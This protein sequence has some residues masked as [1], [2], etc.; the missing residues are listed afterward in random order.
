[1]D[2]L[3]LA[4]IAGPLMDRLPR[5]RVMIRADVVRVALAAV[6]AVWPGRIA[7]ARSRPAPP[8]PRARPSQVEHEQCEGR[9]LRDVPELI[10][11]P[12]TPGLPRPVGAEL[13]LPVAMRD[14]AIAA[15]IATRA[16]G[17]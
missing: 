2:L 8:T 17:A 5:I 10:G 14:F 6:L 15:A 1:M 3:L 13:F 16:F 9:E 7:L 11:A 4:P 12:L